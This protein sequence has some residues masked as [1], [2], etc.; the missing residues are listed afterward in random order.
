MPMCLLLEWVQD[1]EWES[2]GAMES[3]R[4]EMSDTLWNKA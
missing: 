1:I 4:E 3:E 2:N